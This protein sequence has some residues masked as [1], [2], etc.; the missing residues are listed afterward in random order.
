MCGFAGPG[1]A[2]GVGVTKTKET[3]RARASSQGSG[4]EQDFWETVGEARE[5]LGKRRDWVGGA[6]GCGQ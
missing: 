5:G 1:A 2:E 6:S 3:G 4:R